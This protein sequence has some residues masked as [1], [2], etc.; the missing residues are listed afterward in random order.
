MRSHEY[1]IGKSS[2]RVISKEGSDCFVGSTSSCDT[3]YVHRLPARNWETPVA[4]SW[5]LVYVTPSR[6]TLAA[7]YQSGFLMNSMRLPDLKSFS[8]QAPV[9]RISV[10]GSYFSYA[11][12]GMTATKRKFAR[13]PFNGAYG[14]DVFIWNV[15]GSTA[16]QDATG[17]VGSLAVIS[18]EAF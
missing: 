10:R 6:F 18:C 15:I 16:A 2:C 9:P 4:Y 1:E 11:S 14:N 13:K 8:C 12:V 3:A 5:M 7:S 17:A